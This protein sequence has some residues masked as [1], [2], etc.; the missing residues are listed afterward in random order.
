MLP[1]EH[2]LPANGLFSNGCRYEGIGR[3]V[4]GMA[5][6]IT[7]YLTE[8]DGKSVKVRIHHNGQEAP[9]HENHFSKRELLSPLQLW[10]RTYNTENLLAQKDGHL[11]SK[12]LRIGSDLSKVILGAGSCFLAKFRTAYFVA[13]TSLQNIPFEALTIGEH[14]L[15]EIGSVGRCFGMSGGLTTTSDTKARKTVAVINSRDREHLRPG[16]EKEL[17][18]ALALMPKSKAEIYRAENLLLADLLARL[19]QARIFYYAGHTEAGSLPLWQRETLTPT[20]IKSQ[21]LANLNIVFVNGCDSA[22]K[23]RTSSAGL[24]EAFLMAGAKNFVGYSI[25]VSNQLAALV[26]ESFW[27]FLPKH[28]VAKTLHRAR[29][30]A[31]TQPGD[32][33]FGWL[34]L[35]WYTPEPISAGRPLKTRFIVAAAVLLVT[36]LVTAFPLFRRTGEPKTTPKI[37]VTEKAPLDKPNL[38]RQKQAAVAETKQAYLKPSKPIPVDTPTAAK[39][40]S[41]SARPTDHVSWPAEQEIRMREFAAL[42]RKGKY[43]PPKDSNCYLDAQGFVLAWKDFDSNRRFAATHE[44]EHA[45]E[46]ISV[47]QSD[48]KSL[49]TIRVGGTR[50]PMQTKQQARIIRGNWHRLVENGCLNARTE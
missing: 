24:P 48:G 46:T 43:I 50:D 23:S 29:K 22:V 32:R 28:G 20:E 35:Q 4:N 5:A 7:V 2:R 39:V 3:I 45:P 37:A 25:P 8:L 38:P 6:A 1:T 16:V 10:K 34:G 13:P 9:S 41:P 40:Q 26:S 47:D 33:D 12:L 18:H 19:Q 11:R 42:V 15:A 17:T 31:K 14:F 44:Q 27:K 49:R 30:I 21:N 36:L